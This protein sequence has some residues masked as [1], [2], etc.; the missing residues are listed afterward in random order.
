MPVRRLGLEERLIHQRR[1]Q[2]ASVLK[3][4]DILLGKRAYPSRPEPTEQQPKQTIHA[5]DSRS[6]LL[7]FEHWDLLPKSQVLEDKVGSRLQDADDRE[8]KRSDGIEDEALE[9]RDQIAQ[10]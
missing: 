4:G 1:S 8:R 3:D 6:S 2:G 10:Q 5:L 7:P 9:H